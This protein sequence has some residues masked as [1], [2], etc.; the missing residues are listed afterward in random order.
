MMRRKKTKTRSVRLL[1]G[2]HRGTEESLSQVIRHKSTHHDVRDK[3]VTVNLTA[4]QILNLGF[5]HPQYN[6]KQR[7]DILIGMLI[8]YSVVAIPYQIAF[9]IDSEAGW[10]VFD[11]TVDILFAVDICVTAKTPY[12]DPEK[13]TYICANRMI[14]EK[15]VKS[16]FAI[17]FFSTV[18]IDKIAASIALNNSAGGDDGKNLKLVKLIKTLRLIR[19]LKLA[20][21][22]KLGKIQDSLE[23]IFD[24]PNTFKLLKLCLMLFG[25]AH[26]IGC[27]WFAVSPKGTPPHEAWWG[28]LEDLQY[29][30][31]NTEQLYLASFVL[32]FYHHDDSRL[33]GHYAC[34]N[35][36]EV[37]GHCNHAVWGDDIW[38][39]NWQCSSNYYVE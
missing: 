29:E 13:R 5:V 39:R 18:P 3:M 30:Q 34:Y 11:W 10:L 1:V 35:Q 27:A 38:I 9:D 31:D 36:R 7:F 26:M 22:L 21:V 17:D 8:I 6:I 16:W 14:V 4:K 37:V 19:L 2:N 24:S 28:Q 32:G 15:Y 25:C 20:R 12:M 23:D 33:W